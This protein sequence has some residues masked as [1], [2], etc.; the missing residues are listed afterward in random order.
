MCCLV[1]PGVRTGV[2]FQEEIVRTVCPRAVGEYWW[3]ALGTW[4][5]KSPLGLCERRNKRHPVLNSPALNC[6]YFILTILSTCTKA[7]SVRPV[8]ALPI[9][10]P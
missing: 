3:E 8:F 10:V 7:H 4:C 6:R 9:C 5:P 1:P 2:S